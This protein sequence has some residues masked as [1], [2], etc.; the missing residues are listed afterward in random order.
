MTKKKNFLLKT[1][2]NVKLIVQKIFLVL[3]I[4]AKKAT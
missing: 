1:K 3:L 4:Q 2:I